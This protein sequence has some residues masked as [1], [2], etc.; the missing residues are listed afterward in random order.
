L[1]DNFQA[2]AA[3]ALDWLAAM[4]ADEAIAQV[5]FDRFEQSASVSAVAESAQAPGPSAQRRPSLNHRPSAPVAAPPAPRSPAPAA[6]TVPAEELDAMAQGCSTLDEL[7]RLL[8]G[9]DACPLK[10]TAT[11]LCFADGSPGAH[12]MIVGEAPGRDEDEQGRPFVGRSGQLLDKM[13]KAAGFDRDSDDPATSVFITNTVF[14]RPPG[15]RN[16]STAE[17]TMCLPFVRRAIELAAPRLIMTLGNIPTQALLDTKQGITRIRG[18]WKQLEIGGH[19]Y[20]VMPSLHPSYL[21]RSPEAKRLAWRDL[22]D[23]KTRLLSQ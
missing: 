16:P 11:Q 8:D 22:L 18:N 2:A 5:P 15:N 3:K 23:V 7:A 10:R 12:L 17:L 19:V 13:L 6:A 14:W 4:G 21:L 20:Q 1:N 9:F